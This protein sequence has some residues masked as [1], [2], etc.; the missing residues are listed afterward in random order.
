MW[1]CKNCKTSILIDSRFATREEDQEHLK[2]CATCGQTAFAYE[3]MPINT[4]HCPQFNAESLGTLTNC[5]HGRKLLSYMTGSLLVL[6][7]LAATSLYFDWTS[8][9]RS[10]GALGAKATFLVGIALDGIIVRRRVNTYVGKLRAISD[11]DKSSLLR[12]EF[13]TM[14]RLMIGGSLG[15]VLLSI[16]SAVVSTIVF[17]LAILFL[18]AGLV[19]T[20]RD[21]VPPEL[22]EEVIS[23]KTIIFRYAEAL[24]KYWFRCEGEAR[25]LSVKGLPD[26]RK[27]L[28]EL[29][30]RI[31]HK[32]TRIDHALE[33]ID[34]FGPR[35]TQNMSD[36][37]YSAM[38]AI[39]AEEDDILLSKFGRDVELIKMIEHRIL[40][41]H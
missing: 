26:V 11:L 32:I 29:Q 16:T 9:P 6:A 39:D 7:A 34:R 12:A 22:R 23:A 27:A 28:L 13:K 1:H 17:S 18:F 41:D 19:M 3:P 40:V 35:E 5:A 21:K 24:D 14:G 10:W 33:E 25:G 38:V 37:P 2:N 4:S 31:Y 8:G 36:L 15:I 30:N 20:L